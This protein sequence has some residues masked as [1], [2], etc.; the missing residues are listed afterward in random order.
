MGGL[1][2]GQGTPGGGL[3]ASPMPASTNAL[4]G[5]NQNM[6]AAT[7]LYGM[8]YTGPAGSGGWGQL[9]AATGG[10]GGGGMTAGTLA[11]MLGAGGQMI[12][13][14]G[15]GGG[16]P[17]VQPQ[18]MPQRMGVGGPQPMGGNPFMRQ[19]PQVQPRPGMPPPQA[20]GQGGNQ[21]GQTMGSLM[22]L[23]GMAAL[24]MG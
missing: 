16:I 20:G 5:Q 1:L 9:N 2:G 21:L 24:L 12:G 13:G 4:G 19:M 10:G 23:A 14:M 18:Q 22:Q 6:I 11:Q 15:G 7:D 8:P 3:T 17:P